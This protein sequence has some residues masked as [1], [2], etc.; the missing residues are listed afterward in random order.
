MSKTQVIVTKSNKTETIVKA[1]GKGQPVVLKAEHGARYEL[2]DLAKAK[3][4]AIDGAKF[5][6]VG[7]SLHIVL[8]NED[9]ASLVIEDYYSVYPDGVNAVVGQAENGALYEYVTPSGSVSGLQADT[10]A[11][12]AALGTQAVSAPAAVGSA[13]GNYGGTAALLG[14]LGAGAAAASG[15]K[16]AGATDLMIKGQVNAGPVHAGITVYA[17]DEQGQLLGKTEVDEKGQWRI[18][19]AG[20]AD[21]KGAVLVVAVDNNANETNFLDEVTAANKSMDT[22]LRAMA[23]QS[24]GSNVIS[25][26]GVR[27]LTVNITPVT[28]LAVRQAGVTEDKAPAGNVVTQSNTQ[29]A[30]ALGVENLDITGDVTTTISSDF[31]AGDGLNSAEKY[32]LLLTKLSGLDKANNGN[33]DASLK[34][35]IEALGQPSSTDSQAL[36]EQGRQEAL[37]AVQDNVS[38]AVFAVNTD[39]NRQLLGEVLISSQHLD[40]NGHLVIAGTAMPG[41]TITVTTAAGSQQVL[42]DAQGRFSLTTTQAQSQFNVPLSVQTTDGM[43]QTA[44]TTMALKPLVTN[45]NSI[46]PESVATLQPSQVS[47]LTPQAIAGMSAQEIGALSPAAFAALSPEQLA[48][49]TLGNVTG[50][51][52]ATINGLSAEQLA[53]LNG[54]VFNLLS[55]MAAPIIT[56]ADLAAMSAEQLYALT[57]LQV[58]RLTDDVVASLTAAQIAAMS[59]AGFSGLSVT[60]LASLSSAA[61]GGITAAQVPTLNA[62]EI[63]ALGTA[64]A[65]LGATAMGALSPEQFA[66]LTPAQLAALSSA[67]VAALSDAVIASMTGGQ[68]AALS[69]EAVTGLDAS[70]LSMLGADTVAALTAAQI[71]ALGTSIANLSSAGMGALSPAQFA[72]LTPAQLA[73]LGSEDVAALSNAV[74]DSLTA[75]QVAA[76]SP[77]GFSGLS[78]TD[79]SALSNAAVGGITAAQV[80]GLDPSEIA[81]LGTDIANLGSAAMASLTPAQFAALTPAQLAALGSDDVAALNDDVIDSLTSAQVAALSTAAFAGLSTADLD[82]L[83]SAAVAGMT[84]EQVA[85]LNASEINALGTDIAHIGS[86]AMGALT[87][88]QFAALTPAQITALGG[89]DVA[90]LSDDVIDSLTAT[91]IAAL[92]TAGITGLS[93]VDLAALGSSAVEGL[94]AEHIATFDD[95]EIEA[96]GTDIANLS[97]AAMGALTP[98]QFAALT[99]AQLAALGSEDMAALS[100]E[101]IESL[102]ETQVAALSAAGFSGLSSADLGLLTGQAVSGITTAQLAGLDEIEIVAL[103]TDIAQLTPAA[104]AALTSVQFA[105]MTPEQF[106][107]LSEAQLVA[108]TGENISALSDDVIDSLTSAQVAALSTAG[109]D[110]LSTSDLD[111]LSAA[112]VMGLTAEQ[113]NILDATDIV[114]LGTD[115]SSLSSLAMAAMSTMQMAALTIAQFAALTTGQLAALDS[116]DVAALDSTVVASMTSHQVAALSPQGFEGLSSADLGSL[117]SD[118]VQGITT[119]HIAGLDA[120]EIQ[121]LGTDIA[122][123]GSAAMGA[124]STAQIIALTPEQIAAL[125]SADVA[126]LDDN[127]IANLS[128]AQVAALSESGFSGLSTD[129]LIALTSEAVIGI[130]AAHMATLNNT[131][132]VALGTDI[133]NLGSAAM[134]ALT[135]EQ[136][137]ALTTEQIAALGSE[138][139]AALTSQALTGLSGAQVAALT[140][141]AFG[142]LGTDDLGALTSE[143]VQGITAAQVVTLE[144]AEVVALGTD[145]ANLGAAAMGALTSEQV[146]AMEPAQVAALGSEDLAAMSAIAFTGLSSEDLGTLS[147][148]AVQGITSEQIDSLDAA[149]VAALGTDIANLGSAA[150]ASL[151]SEQVAAMESTQIAALGSEDLAAMS[152]IAFTG[153]SSAQV[154][155]LSSDAFAAMGTDDLG[156]LTSDAVQGITAAQAGT[157]DATEVVALGTDIANLGASAMGALTSVQVAAMESTQIA[158]LGS[159]DLAAMSALAFTGL[160][161]EDLGTL[162]SA[163]V[164]G[165]T[166]AQVATLEAAEVVALGT[167]IANLGAAAMGALT[168]EQ[169]AAM[170]PAQVAALGSEDL[171]AMSALAFTGLSSAQVAA[172]SSDAFAAMGT[173]DLGALTSD[174][175]QGITAAQVA[176]LEA[177]EVVALG[178][179]IAN[180]GAAAMGA[181]TSAQVA[182]MEPAQFAA[183]DTADL[184]TL[185]SEAVAGITTAQVETL[186]ATDIA[187]LGTDIANLSTAAMGALTSVQVEAMT[188]EQIAALGSEDLAAMSAIAFTGLRS[189]DLGTLTSA[190]VQ[191]IT[192][193]QIDSLDAAEVAALGID[194]ANLGSAALASLTS[195]QVAALT[196][197]QIASLGSEDLAALTSQ[198]LTGLSSAQV[199]ALSTAAFAAL[200]TDDLSALTSAAVQ[201]ITTAH[202]ATLEAVE[203]V[204][205]GTDIANLGVAAMGAL[206][207]VQVAAMESTQIAA[208]GSEDLAAMSAL[209]FTGLSSEDLGTLTSAAVQGITAAQVATL[210]AAE[211]A[212]L[213][214]DIANLGAAAMGALTSEQVAAMESTQVAALGSEDLAA[215]SA[216]AFTGLSSEDL[217]TL[218]SA[219]VQGITSEQIDSL[220]AAE[221]AALGT[222][223]ANLGSAALASLTSE[224]VA[225]LTLEQIAALGSED[226]AAMSAIAFTGLSSAQVAALSSD[227]FAAM[228]T[229]DL[230]ALTSDAV[231]GITAAQVATL[232]ATEVAA[233]GTDIA[234]LGAAAMGALTSV[235]VAAMESTQ[236]AAL[237]SE[238]LAAMSA[239]AFTGLS[240]EDLGTLTSAAVQ[241]IT[242]AQVGTLEAAEVVALGTDIANLGAAAMGALTSE[243]VAAMESTQIA[244]LGSEDLAAMSAL[245]FT[246]LSSEDLGTLTSAAVQGIT[247]EQIDSLDAA[248]VVALGNDIANLGSAALASL[249]SE[250]VA[251]LTLEQIAV[252]GSEDL[253]ALTSQALTGLSSAQVAALSTAAFA[254]LGTDD[255]GAL[256]SDAVQGITAAQVATLEAAEVV[257][258]GT[259]I[260]NLGAA[261]MGALT[262]AQ[263]AAMESTQIA[264]LGSEDLTA[265]SALAFT[266]LSSEDLGTLTSAAVQGITS[267]QIDSLNAAEVVALGTDIA[268]LGSAAMGA[269]TS[270]QV[271]AL[272]LP[273]FEQLDTADLAALGSNGVSGITIDQ[274]V[275]LNASEIEA[276]GTDIAHLSPAAMGALTRVQVA[277]LTSAQFEALDTAD[278]VALSS[279]AVQGI[280]AAQVV[281]LSESDVIALGTD[282][283]NMDSA[284]IGALTSAQLSA[285]TTAQIAALDSADI[286]ALNEGVAA[287]LTS[288]QVAALSAPAF[289]A[290]SPTDLTALTVD[291]AAGVTTAQ[292]QTLD[293]TDIAAL[294]TDIANLG[295]A[296]MGALTS[297]QLAVF[298]TDQ[299]A[300]LDSADIAAL[301]EGVAAGLTSAQVAALSVPAFA[302]LSPTDLTALTVDAAAGVT[303]A[304][305]QTLDSTDIAALGT[306]IANLGTAAM[307]A[308][309]SAQLAVFST[310]QIAALD[311]ADIAALNEGVTAGL[312]SAQVA[313]LSVP[314]FA[315]LSPTDLTALTVDAA[316]GVTTAQVETLDSTDIAALGTDI[317]NLG[318][319]AMGA[320]TSAQLAVFS[321]DQIAALDSADIAALNEGVAAGLTSAQVAALSVPAFAALS[322]TDLT[323]LTVDAAA[324]VTTAQVETLDS[325]DIAA[326]G[327]DIANL[328]TAAMGA[329]T[330]AQLAA[331]STAQIAALDS[332]DIAALNDGVVAGLSS[333]QMAILTTAQFEA[334]GTADLAAL[335]S[336]A[337]AGITASQVDSLNSA[338]MAALGTDIANLGSAAM[339]SLD[340]TQIAALS[341]TQ[342]AALGAEDYAALGVAPVSAGAQTSLLQDVTGLSAS[343]AVNETAELQ[344]LAT[345]TDAVMDVAALA[346]TAVTPDDSGLTAFWAQLTAL[347]VS[348]VTAENIGGVWQAVRNT[349]DSGT[350]VD[351][352][353][354]INALVAAVNDKPTL[355]AGSTLAYTEND[356]ASAINTT[357]TVGDADNATLASATVKISGGYVAGQDVLSFTANG[358]MGNIAGVVSG[359]TV[360]LT[361]AG[362]TATHAQWQ[363]ALRAVSYRNTSENPNTGDRTV[364]YEINDG[365]LI[366]TALTSTI[367]VTAT[368]DQPASATFANLFVGTEDQPAPIN[369]TTLGLRIADVS[370][371]AGKDPESVPVG[372]AI[373]EPVP[374]SKGTAWYSLDDGATWLNLSTATATASLTNAFVLGSSA[375]LYFHG[376]LNAENSMG[377]FTG[378]L[379]DGTDGATSGQSKDISAL[380]GTTGAYSATN[381][382]LYFVLTSVND[383][384]VLTAG[385]TLA[386]AENAAATAISSALTVSD[387]DGSTL[388]SAT[389]QISGGYVAGQDVLSFTANGATMGNIAAVIAGDTVTLTSAGSTATKD[390]WQAALRAVSY[391]NTSENPTAGARTVSYVVNDGAPIGALD[392]APVTSTINVT[393]ANDAPV[394]NN[395]LTL[396]LPA[397]MQGTAAPTNGSV[398][399]TLVKDL[400]AGISDVDVNAK[401]GIA[402]TGINTALGTL[403]VSMDDGA[404]WTALAAMSD[405]SA[406]ALL[407]DADN[408][409]YYVPKAGTTG[410]VSDAFTFRAWDASGGAPD[411][412]DINAATQTAT[413]AVSS[414]SETVSQ[415]VVKPVVI[416]AVSTNNAVN[417]NETLVISGTAENNATVNLQLDG[418]TLSVTADGS[419]NWSYDGSKVRYIMVYKEMAKTLVNDGSNN[420]LTNGRFDVSEIRVMDGATNRA[421]GATIQHSTGWDFLPAGMIDG[422]TATANVSYGSSGSLGR[423]YVQIDLGAAYNL[424]AIDLVGVT[425]L[426]ASLN[427]AVIYTSLSDMWSTTD[428]QRMNSAAINHVVVS[429]ASND[430]LTYTV[431][432][433]VS[434]SANGLLTGSNTITASETVFGLSSTATKAVVST[435]TMSWANTFDGTDPM[436]GGVW[437]G[438]SSGTTANSIVNAD[439]S[440]GDNEMQIINNGVLPYFRANSFVSGPSQKVTNFDVAFDMDVSGLTS[441]VTNRFELRY[442]TAGNASN[443]TVAFREGGIAVTFKG[444]TQTLTGP[445]LASLSAR[446]TDQATV[447]MAE[448]GTLTISLAGGGTPVSWTANIANW[449]TDNAAGGRFQFYGDSLSNGSSGWIDNVQIN[450]TVASSVV[451]PT[452][453][454]ISVYDNTAAETLVA[455]GTGNAD[456]TPLLKGTATAGSTVN[457]YEGTQ[458]LGT[459]TVDGTGAWTF[460]TTA[461]TPGAHTLSVR[462]VDAQ[463]NIGESTPVSLLVESSTS[464]WTWSN[465]FDN[466]GDLLN[467]GGWATPNTGGTVGTQANTILNVNAAD[468]DNEFKILNGNT[469]PYYRTTANNMPGANQQTTAFNAQ[470]DLDVSGVYSTSDKIDFRYTNGAVSS[471][472][473]GYSGLV[474]TFKENAI[475]VLWNNLAV[476]PSSSTSLASLS[477][478]STDHVTVNMAT[479]GTLT[480]SMDD[481][482]TPL[483]WTGIIPNTDG[484]WPAYVSGHN[485]TPGVAGARFFFYGNGSNS[486]GATGWIDNVAITADVKSTKLLPTATIDSVIDDVG[487]TS[488]LTSGASTN[489]TLPTLT[490]TATPGTTVK[491]FDG[492]FYLGS[493]SAHLTTGVWTF[494]TP[495]TKPLSAGLHTLNVRAMDVSN[496]LGEATSFAINVI[497][498]TVTHVA[499]S[500]DAGLVNST[501]NA[502]D[503]VTASLTMSEAVTVTGTPQLSLNI[504]GTPVQATYDSVNSTPTS[505]KFSYTILPGH[506]DVNGITVSADALSLNGSTI[507][508]TAGLNATLALPPLVEPANLIVGGE[509]PGQ[510]GWTLVGDTGFYSAINSPLTTGPLAAANTEGGLGVFIN[511]YTGNNAI[512]GTANAYAAGTTYTFAFD[513]EQMGAN[514][515]DVA[516]FKWQLLDA[517]TNA[518]VQDITGWYRTGGVN[519]TQTG[520]KLLTDGVWENFSN[521]FTVASTGNYKLALYT[522]IGGTS[523]LGSDFAID[524]VYMSTPSGMVDTTAPTLTVS[525]PVDGSATVTAASNLTLT[526]SETV[527]QG[528]GTVGIYKMSDNTLVES[529]DVASSSRI[530][531]WNGTTL[532]IDPTN[533]LD[534]GT[535]YYVKVAPTAVKDTAGNAYAGIAD[536]STLNFATLNAD[537]ST[538]QAPT[539]SVTNLTT[540]LG[541]ALD[542]GST[543][544]STASSGNSLTSNFGSALTMGD[545]TASLQSF[546]ATTF[547]GSINLFGVNYTG[548]YVG[549][550]G[551]VTFGTQQTSYSGE[552]LQAWAHNFPV[553]AAFLVDIDVLMSSKGLSTGGNS[554]GSGKVWYRQDATG[555]MVTYD[556]VSPHAITTPTDGTNQGNAFQIKMVQ[557]QLNGKNYQTIELVYEN[558]SWAKGNTPD[559]PQAGWSAGNTFPGQPHNVPTWSGSV[560]NALAQAETSSNINRAGVW[561]WV[562]DGAT[563]QQLDVNASTA[564]NTFAATPVSVASL[565]SSS[566]AAQYTLVNDSNGRFVIDAGTNPPSVKTVAGAVFDSSEATA[567]VTVRVTDSASGLSSEQTITVNLSDRFGNTANNTIGLRSDAEVTELSSG[568]PILRIDGAAGFDSLKLH[569]DGRA[570]NLSTVDDVVIKNVEKIDLSAT[571]AQTL[572]LSNADVTAMSSTNLIHTGTASADGRV[573]TNTSG[574]ALTDTTAYAQLVVDGT[575][576]DTVT[577][578]A[579]GTGFWVNAGTVSNGTST[580]VVYQNA[581]TNS[582]VI[583]QSGVVVVNNDS[584]A[585]IVLDVNGDG[586]LAYSQVAM[587]VNGDGHLD[588]TAWA[589]A[590][591]GVL[592]WDKNGDGVVRDAS[593][594]AFTQY[595]GQTDLQGLAAG[596]DSNGDGVLDAA[597]AK[598]AEFAVWQDA[599]QNGVSDAGEVRSLADVGVTSID[600]SSDGVTNSP[601]E[602]VT[603]AGRTTAQLADGREMLVADAEFAYSDLSYRVNA[604][605]D[606]SLLGEQ[607]NLDLSSLVSVH[608]ALHSVDLTGTGANSLKISLSDL[609][610]LGEQQPL[611]VLGDADDSVVLDA[612]QWAAS[613][614]A[615][616]EGHSYA[617]YAAGSGQQL[618][619]EQTIHTV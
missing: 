211:V 202:I 498:P 166:A 46:T 532:T 487:G 503:T 305:V 137:A 89:D 396:A 325:T 260:A 215:M 455:T 551:F 494:V 424:S 133:A 569:G 118:A 216:L 417:A 94:T 106:A 479:D 95:N 70:D 139:L 290:L 452:V 88:E 283:A 19:A 566:G 500:G 15:K 5:K 266:G 24:E 378:R 340:S 259:D 255:L 425:N 78:T 245:A 454:T 444:V 467:G 84:A 159:E 488:A 53:A 117:T 205:L 162:T 528:T 384:P 518:F 63:A 191:G 586:T 554:T 453:G 618:W 1:F 150:L 483:T 557:S 435:S 64:L 277:A 129:N 601:A 441:N 69:S 389:V 593:Q 110:G 214:T 489:D 478:R 504:G 176:T 536:S 346:N 501:F 278:L 60:D 400:V 97:S 188:S 20:R 615:Q 300:A 497:A 312:T 433:P 333:A 440:D 568:L 413:S 599:N 372:V 119:A 161:S 167:D 511:N 262:S 26:G 132:V 144:A 83:T 248:E 311:S 160:S 508:G 428:A 319:A 493:A 135:S 309:T 4:G 578:A 27:V 25:D 109:I 125:D 588:N 439:T 261:A 553:I 527:L 595:G 427:G 140:T 13:G 61:V 152:A 590:Q 120:T 242:A 408:R 50:L 164:Q 526:F 563:G 327:A 409:L 490:G 194:I 338:D 541:S 418:Q 189:E 209:A 220:D 315:A 99:P 313:A 113:M 43:G 355:S 291:A 73:A 221:V 314:A 359:S 273:Q 451:L 533:S 374:T 276:L 217:G 246:G 341:N 547:G 392:S 307:G 580:Y 148:A 14:A 542:S 124:L 56:S 101:V 475:N 342:V 302:A 592:V 114:A 91:Q 35:L 464:T 331:F 219:A 147:S 531:G 284:A 80:P 386:Y 520:A 523:A 457:V 143:A 395:S 267:E 210:E 330:S 256:T 546:G 111:R 411:G 437:Q 141:A 127:V 587:D 130:T 399:G 469:L 381:T 510:T 416:N 591:D 36:L 352:L 364:T 471:D 410:L 388:A 482:V 196:T 71:A 529:F 28:E 182:A 382:N 239:L 163:A 472:G 252:L 539:L 247:S 74:V 611:R 237:G 158:A 86:A 335:T 584:V 179:D 103:G 145:I 337:V 544:L 180:L 559:I 136:V 102:T 363:E 55:E 476:T 356:V 8:D 336:D 606:L 371:F 85:T 583:V 603:E 39:A 229:D 390:Q 65:N 199:A 442:V 7:K 82:A 406:R 21:Y 270:E 87:P 40:E 108:L 496:N 79:L 607:M 320:L 562:V 38:G 617:V 122:N 142:A 366:S 426:G 432:A 30:K 565:S 619:L 514:R 423:G 398:V 391:S 68:I 157:L 303:T 52:A 116:T 401:T 207:S 228:G 45:A 380:T 263:V 576:T 550:N 332:A 468:A 447:T 515:T 279:E 235:Q 585:P 16:D 51:K 609:L 66:A 81:A 23:V 465:S 318:T 431:T 213:G 10:T 75:A 236:I 351:S 610:S 339:G 605:G 200:G 96:L 271:A 404:T 516:N 502:G 448:N 177:T 90:A 582:Q 153:L 112:A 480:I 412:T 105:A 224:Q 449:T 195:E 192:S 361:S 379:W 151:T 175:V 170:E 326:L 42:V 190:A 350:G 535:G 268:S 474:V 598:F 193:E 397:L 552:N 344:T 349:A 287:G 322:P 450:A 165:I 128:S 393:A 67:D 596:F 77:A 54:E 292:V 301:N 567:N 537:G 234:N 429:G 491:V 126:A 203:V 347:G 178:T 614:T 540:S 138:D 589:G 369:G 486:L 564:A 470:F 218:T 294:G 577:L 208:L 481:G 231:Q 549:S 41:S 460:E 9:T 360:T 289:A 288:A 385:A 438:T 571:G 613:G 98:D 422:S 285:L 420:Y 173:D 146:A 466:A 594:Y 512:F 265:M 492:D 297:A 197:E 93:T 181:L 368:N 212:A 530:T 462:A 298:S 107:A 281:T 62:S 306:D 543:L 456:T 506:T 201:G 524:R 495:S 222:D 2:E 561:R 183:L 354:K 295:T 521:T 538:P 241:G 345:A 430:N 321:T 172:L 254:A 377:M 6:R 505:L 383:A 525:T 225:A 597:D 169:V 507:K 154:A 513:A 328:G 443:L 17:Y 387:V 274:L 72:V 134:G 293:S 519:G 104:M 485:A 238:D 32:G 434:T 223:I 436:A 334:L 367:Q 415:Y 343:A 186:E 282:I 198:A 31:K 304:Q 574:N 376:N 402:I 556:D 509:A 168:S 3:K 365:S 123:L 34:Q 48:A 296:A 308:L 548:V 324:G 47:G 275:T 323:A 499:I 310:D 473:L 29:V 264:A 581:A 299:I 329:L 461:L 421:L 49:L 602:G 555:F 534:N 11:V 459:A 233:L 131:E 22:S 545:D 243:Q 375:R 44:T 155:A 579:G 463:G 608:G 257:A 572:T 76:L 232:E 616:S 187:A 573:W 249:T 560:A 226:L 558:I 445:T 240:S 206:T 57:P 477:A 358:A 484:G 362:S 604:E 414:A 575:A 251:A 156:A 600:L 33:I 230:G 446:S 353:A 357:I 18:T 286:A 280:T 403:Y 272:S 227:A 149:E 348:G 458:L 317:A 517:T 204:A 59:P 269:L 522:N 185:T 250:Q 316:A 373:V 92:S 171:A 407:A 419:G 570:L 58:S 370:Y 394:L 115:I 12:A 184:A 121:A 37:K 258:L 100:D 405:S 174:A 244:A 612:T 253:A